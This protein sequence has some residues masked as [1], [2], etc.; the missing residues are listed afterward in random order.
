MAGEPVATVL[1]LPT[2]LLLAWIDGVA[3]VA[4]RV[5]L[6]S[7]DLARWA[8]LTASVVLAVTTRPV[9]DPA[10]PIGLVPAGVPRS[11]LVP[12]GVPPS[13]WGW[14]RRVRR[15]VGLAGL[16]VVTVTAV[17][18][19][20]G[21]GGRTGAVELSAGATLWRAGGAAVAMVDGRAEAAAFVRDVLATGVTR[22]DVLVVATAS[23]RAAEVAGDARERWPR[24]VVLAP[25]E[26]EARIA[27]AIVPP[28]G[29]VVDVG[30]VR[31]HLGPTSR[32]LRPRIELLPS[33]SAAPAGSR[34]GGPGR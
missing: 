2:R 30:G 8:V 4:A 21:H 29:R 3:T 28:P 9:R 15:G 16:V 31:L 24:L 5:P 33:T 26:A 6:G 23:P 25:A 18:P 27:G 13:R 10:P 19:G 14:G 22:L 34:G 11:A 1:H 20:A 32:D 17:V 12:A 7:V